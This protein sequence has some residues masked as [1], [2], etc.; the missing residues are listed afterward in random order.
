MNKVGFPRFG[1]YTDIFRE[2]FGDLGIEVANIPTTTKRTI[3]IGAKYSPEMICIPFKFSLGNFIEILEKEQNITLVHY[4]TCGKCRFHAYYVTQ[5]QILEDIGYKFEMI[6]LSWTRPI[7]TLKSIKKLNPDCSY[8][9]IIRG[10]LKAYKKIKEVDKQDHSG[11]LKIGVFGEI[12]T[13][14]DEKCNIDIVNKLKN[15]GCYVENS[16]SLNYFLKSGIDIFS[17]R[18]EKKEAKKLLP[19]EIG[20]H[21]F[22]SIVSMIDFCKRNFAGCL[23]LRPLTCGPEVHIEPII[24]K[25][26]KQYKMP[27]LILN[28]DEN[29]SEQNINTRLETFIDTLKMKN[30]RSITGD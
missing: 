21:A 18:K 23:F 3:E 25:L 30:E 22:H 5:K 10:F 19:E 16:L 1:V 9:R 15:A 4:K 14:V 6:V 8:V 20:G 26:S 27:L 11:N 2:M 24:Q 7:K 12:F 17:K 29:I 28:F 13:C